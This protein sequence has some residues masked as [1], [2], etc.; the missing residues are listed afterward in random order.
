[1]KRMFPGEYREFKK[2]EANA[3]AFFWDL[4]YMGR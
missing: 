4:E 2:T 1:M 3:N